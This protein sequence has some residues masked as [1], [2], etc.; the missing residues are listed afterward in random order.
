MSNSLSELNNHLFAQL[1]R[2]S[3]TSLKGDKL[4]QEIER[5]K[6]LNQVATKIIDNGSLV[7]QAHKMI[8]DRMNADLTLPKM[9]E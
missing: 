3:D 1:D 2:L 7:L 4:K 8:D 6:A 5:S 9:L